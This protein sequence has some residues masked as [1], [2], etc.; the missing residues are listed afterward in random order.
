MSKVKTSK[1]YVQNGFNKRV[2]MVKNYLEG[3]KC[4]LKELLKGD[5]C[6]ISPIT[7][8]SDYGFVEDIESVKADEQMD[9]VTI[10]KTSK[11]LRSMKHV[12]VAMSAK[13][14]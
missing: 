10:M 2:Y 14:Y 1:V 13:L 7:I 6:E 3:V 4:L 12:D 8:C 11:V 9:N 5:H